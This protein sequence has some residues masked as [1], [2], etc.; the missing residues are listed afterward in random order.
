M[1]AVVGAMDRYLKGQIPIGL[2]AEK[3]GA[4]LD[5]D[6]FGRRAGR[7]MRDKIAPLPALGGARWW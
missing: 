5:H 6:E 3:D 1:L 7:M 4:T 2:A